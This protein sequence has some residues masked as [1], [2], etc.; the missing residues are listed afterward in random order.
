M[1]AGALYSWKEIAPFVRVGR[2]T[3][4][5]RVNAGTAPQPVPMGSRCTRYRGEDVQAWIAN[6]AGYTAAKKRPVRRP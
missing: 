1:L 4:R 5:R 2:E 3:W 6:P